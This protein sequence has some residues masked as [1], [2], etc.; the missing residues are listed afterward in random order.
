MTTLTGAAPEV[1]SSPLDVEAV[2]ERV[3]AAALRPSEVGS[4]GLEL[5]RHVVDLHD[6]GSR[7][8]WDRLT[9]LLEGFAT[10]RGSKV[11]LEPGGQV[12]LSTLP[13]DGVVAAVEALRVDADVLDAR[14][15]GERLV[16]QST[17]TDPLRAPQ[18]VNP[19]SRYVSM[20]RHFASIGDTAGPAMMSSTASLQVNLDA[21]PAHGWADRLAHVHRLLPVFVALAASSPVQGGTRTGWACARQR[22]WQDLEPGRSRAGTATSDPVAAW[23]EF[24]LA[25]PVMFLRGGD[26]Q[27][28]PVEG[29]VS[30]AAWADGSVRLGDRSPTAADVDAHLTTLWPPVRLRGFLELRVLDAVPRAWW[31][32]LA[33]VVATVVD[34]PTAA[35]RA[36]EAA[37]PVAHAH[38]E[39]ARD[40]LT[41]PR[42]R[43]AA[44]GVL[45]AAAARVP[46]GLAAD[47][48]RWL[49]ALDRGRGPADLVLD[50]FERSGPTAC[51]TAEELR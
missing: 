13:G 21:G 10:P 37:H 41:D 40:G 2:R 42:I 3:A 35:D 11:T 32:G 43:T 22:I 30:F 16:L 18:R 50:R 36:A 26:G 34:D 39:A 5:E 29:T 51:L 1:D 17:G 48:E 20:E 14:L 25:A 9:A 24:A 28:T 33:A 47:V 49:E 46:D 38:L 6:P 45:E 44:L 27:F 7:V 8:G 31:P 4:V 15:A 23:T 19:A 12:E